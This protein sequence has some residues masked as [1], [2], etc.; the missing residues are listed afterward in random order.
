MLSTVLIGYDSKLSRLVGD[1]KLCRPSHENHPITKWVGESLQNFSWTLGYAR[2]LA[3]EFNYRFSRIH[4]SYY[5]TQY[6]A[7]NLSFQHDLLPKASGTIVIFPRSKEESKE[8]LR[9]KWDSQDVHLSGRKDSPRTGTG[10]ETMYLDR[11]RWNIKKFNAINLPEVIGSVSISPTRLS[12]GPRVRVLDMPIHIPGQGLRLPQETWKFGRVIH[13]VLGEENAEYGDIGDL[14][15]Y[16]TIDQ[17]HVKKGIRVGDLEP[18]R[19]HIS[20]VRN[21]KLTSFLRI[22]I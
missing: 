5:R 20:R 17:K 7:T 8:I 15:V 2:Y 18:T 6:I 3:S 22:L 19:M 21:L 14:Y 13:M 9:R 1:Y 4:N 11:E 12:E 10:G 16:L